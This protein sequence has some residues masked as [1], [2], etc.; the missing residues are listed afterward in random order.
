MGT[1]HIKIM[2]Y[3]KSSSERYCVGINAHIRQISNLTIYFKEL[4]RKEQT[5]HNASRKKGKQIRLEINTI[6]IRKK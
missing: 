4:E 2:G 5:K 3:N 6:K 1:E